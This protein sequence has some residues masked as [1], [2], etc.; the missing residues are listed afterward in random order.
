MEVIEMKKVF[1]VLLTLALVFSMAA[2]GSGSQE[3]APAPA[4]SGGGETVEAD[5]FYDAHYKIAYV[6]LGASSDIFQICATRIQNNAAAMGMTA[7]IYFCDGDAAKYIDTVDTLINQKY[8]GLILSH[9]KGEFSLDIA[10]KVRAAG[11]QLV[12][13][14]TYLV[15]ENGNAATV[16]GVTSCYQGDGAMVD[17]LLNYVCYELFPEKVKAGEPVRM[18]EAMMY[19]SEY[20]PFGPRTHAYEKWEEEGL[21]TT[22]EQVAPTSVPEGETTLPAILGAALAKYPVG[23]VDAIFCGYDAFARGC[24]VALK[25]AGRTDIPLVTV[26]I[27]NSD[28]ANMLDGNEVWKACATVSFDQ[29]GDQLFKILAMKLH[30]DEMDEPVY[31]MNPSL[32]TADMLDDKANV[33]NLDQYV[34]GYGDSTAHT[35]D[36]MSKYLG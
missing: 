14:D 6:N 12:E 9:G 3:P 15:D 5:P 36:W 24:Y 32:I 23:S 19:L 21:I 29:V 18:L 7:D 8:D 2:C 26:D 22:V 31:Y 27:A 17:L 1:A 35:P 25:D 20:D 33:L 28:I 34:P 30:G 11:I 13:F 10:K 4:S 16:E